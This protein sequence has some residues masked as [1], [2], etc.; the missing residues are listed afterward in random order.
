MPYLGS[1]LTMLSDRSIWRRYIFAVVAMA[2][3]FLLTPL[4]RD[5]LHALPSGLFALAVV[6]SALYGG[7]G[8]ALLALLVTLLTSSLIIPPSPPDPAHH[9]AHL[10]GGVIISIMVLLLGWQSSARRRARASARL[11]A[12]AGESLAAS[13][14]SDA[15]LA[16]AARLAVPALAD[17]CIVDLMSDNDRPQCVA[18]SFSDPRLGAGST[19]LSAAW[20]D[21]IRTGKARVFSGLSEARLRD[22]IADEDRRKVLQAQGVSSLLL[23]PLHARGRVLGIMTLLSSSWLRRFGKADLTL[24]S[25]LGQ[26]AA[27]AID[28]ARLYRE[29]RDMEAVMRRRADQLTAADRHKDEFLAVVAHELRG[30]LAALRNAVELVRLC[31]TGASVAEAPQGIMARQ[32]DALARLVDDLLDVA[33]ITQGKVSLQRQTLNLEEVLRAAVS[34]TRPLIDARRHMLTVTL[35]RVALWLDGDALRL[36]QVFVNLLTNAA[37]Y[38]EPGGHIWL[39]ADCKGDGDS[40]RALISIRDTGL[41]MAP[42]VLARAFDLFAQ[43]TQPPGR[44]QG[45]MGIGLALVRR[46]VEMHGGRVLA[47]SDGPGKG[48]EFVVYLPLTRDEGRTT[49]D[50][51]METIAEQ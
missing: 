5:Y 39:S 15:T 50:Q 42:E 41:G 32:V 46:L 21:A 38:T 17:G 35:P 49:K 47:H 28:N 13:L 37:K 3:A 51:A 44:S 24:A 2:S 19:V 7:A 29:A 33:R 34:T 6:A 18:A 9:A 8:P 36:E 31:G 26:R 22:L 45:G 48:S 10:A 12:E 30:P 43:G 27:L 23:V 4:L 40:P 14:E 1:R 16:T 20:T 25:E 11:L